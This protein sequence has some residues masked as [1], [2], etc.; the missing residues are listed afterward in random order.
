[1]GRVTC[2]T[3][4]YA[5][6]PSDTQNTPDHYNYLHELHYWDRVEEMETSEPVLAL[7]GSG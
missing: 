4:C 5:D 3:T 7:R 1:M 2:L 6:L